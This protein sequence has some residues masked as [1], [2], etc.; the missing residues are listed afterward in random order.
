M[1]NI[2]TKLALGIAVTASAIAFAQPRGWAPGDKPHRPK[3]PQRHGQGYDTFREGD[4]KPGRDDRR[5]DRRDPHHGPVPIPAPRPAPP[6]HH[7]PVPPP[8]RY[9]PPADYRPGHHGI[10]H[11]RPHDRDFYRTWRFLRHHDFFRFDVLPSNLQ[12]VMRN[13]TATDFD[14]EER[15]ST[16]YTWFA[17]YDATFCDVS[18]VHQ[19]ASGFVGGPGRANIRLSAKYPG[20]TLVELIYARRWEWDRG[21]LPEKVIQLYVHIDP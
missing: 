2:F 3:E 11:S 12:I 8:H 16:G 20:D 7:G 9:G 21:A 1:N 17:R 6:P 5:D 18:I 19:N 14:L 13:F 10:F 4:Y 15:S